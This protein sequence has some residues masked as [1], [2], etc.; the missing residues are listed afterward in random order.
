MQ[1]CHPNEQR[2]NAGKHRKVDDYWAERQSSLA[3]VG[4]NFHQVFPS[5]FRPCVSTKWWNLD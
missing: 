1:N 2:H 4:R 3:A 5:Y